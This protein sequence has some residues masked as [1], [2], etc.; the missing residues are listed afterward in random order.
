MKAI[1]L[2]A[3]IGFNLL[4][5]KGLSYYYS[6]ANKAFDYVQAG[7]PSIQMDFPEYKSLQAQ[8]EVFV[9]LPD[10]QPESIANAV[11]KLAAPAAYGL[12]AENC[13]VAAEAWNWDEEKKKLEAVYKRV[14]E[15]R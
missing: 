13:I 2:Q 10:L 11:Q 5:N 9:L 6:L 8:H 3:D 14:F 4:E 12:L 15:T 7:I 1:T